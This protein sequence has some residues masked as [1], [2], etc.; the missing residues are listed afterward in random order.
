MTID[1]TRYSRQVILPEIGPAGQQRLAESAV[2][3]VG[4]G[5]LGSPIALY[6]A[7]AGIGHIG[8]IDGDRVDRTNLHRQI[9]FDDHHV[10]ESKVGTAAERLRQM[11]PEVR[12]TTF[13]EA[14]TAES[15][16]RVMGSCAWDVI[17]DGADNFATR[18]LCNDLAVLSGIPL[19]HGSI[20]RFEG[21]VT[22]LNHQDGPCYRCLYPDPPEPGSVPS[23]GE[24]GVLGVLPGVIGTLMGTEAIKVALGVGRSLAGRLLLYDA[25]DLSFRE[26][27]FDRD[28]SCAVCG[29]ERT[30][31]A[32]E[33]FDYGTF[34]GV[35]HYRNSEMS[36]EEHMKSISVE[37]LAELREK[38]TEH[39]LIDVRESNEYEFANI[40]GELIPLGEVAARKD[41]IPRDTRVIVMCRSGG[42]SSQ[43][44]SMLEAGG[45]TN[46]ENLSGGILAW[47][48]KVD[49]SI[50]KY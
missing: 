22:L 50:P 13:D 46:V 1:L 43:A 14:L 5:G 7:A 44:V 26:L 16:S 18:Y 48:D 34:C 12:I 33:S 25:L 45:W 30:I 11:N 37:E 2:L 23:C 10:G 35:S 31:S 4:T 28:R 21:Q 20:Y 47:A 41:E 32:V 38:G 3:L 36:T 8:L 39:V 17:V 6:L 24:V 27:H 42:R 9:L 49:T 15:S 19:V 40:G 29:P